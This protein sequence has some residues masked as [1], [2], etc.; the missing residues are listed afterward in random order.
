MYVPINIPRFVERAWTRG[1]DAIILDL[2]DSVPM[3]QKEAARSLVKNAIDKVGKAGAEVIVRINH[4]LEMAEKDLGASVWPGLTGVQ[5]PKASAVEVSKIDE[6]MT[7]LEEDR[8]LDD[9]G[10]EILPLIESA[11]GILNA[12][13]IAISTPRIKSIGGGVNLDASLQIGAEPGPGDP[14]GIHRSAEEHFPSVKAMMI[15]AAT[16]AG[17]QPLGSGVGASDIRDVE[18]T[19]RSAVLGRQMGFKGSTCIHPAQVEPLNRGYTPS[20]NEVAYAKRV[21]EV[22][23]EG[24]RKG[25]ASVSLDG[26]MVDIPV[27]ERA[28]ILI[29]RAEAISQLEKMK[30]RALESATV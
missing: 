13:K 26:R 7:A 4:P 11:E 23:R 9:G 16:A 20:Y 17:V 27:V 2:E 10:I 6:M 18:G 15:L 22:F 30:S 8:G 1:A 25:T 29:S 5:Y 24:V 28:K 14:A 12:Y 3:D 19:Y 21:L